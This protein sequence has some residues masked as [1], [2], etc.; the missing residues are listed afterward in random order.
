MPKHPRMRALTEEERTTIDR[1]VRARTASV[2]EVERAEIIDR[3]SRGERVAQIAAQITEYRRIIAF[4]DILV[5]AFAQID[6]RI[7][8]DI[9]EPKLPTLQ[10]EVAS[11]LQKE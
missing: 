8:W 3:A 6:D 5:H 4:R 11:L 9:V 10:H 7:V 2:R 1:L